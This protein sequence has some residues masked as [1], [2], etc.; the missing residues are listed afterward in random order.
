MTGDERG[1]L[2]TAS[3]VLTKNWGPNLGKKIP[4]EKPRE[5]A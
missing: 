4:G 5:T 2:E 3:L 1:R